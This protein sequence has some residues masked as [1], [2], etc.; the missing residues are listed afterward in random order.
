M[1]KKVLKKRVEK[2][3]KKKKKKVE[4]KKKII[5]DLFVL[6]N[7]YPESKVLAH[8]LCL[9]PENIMALCIESGLILLAKTLLSQKY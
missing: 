9:R 5:V 1:L 8:F 6:K 4:K 2:R 3:K 7:I